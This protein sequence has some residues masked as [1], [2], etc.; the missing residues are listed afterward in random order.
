MAQPQRPCYVVVVSY[1]Y[2][3]RLASIS[4]ALF[5]AVSIPVRHADAILV[6][7]RDAPMVRRL[8]VWLR[9]LA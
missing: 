2:A 9:W 6:C 1:S 8:S 3:V 7:L 4:G 5:K